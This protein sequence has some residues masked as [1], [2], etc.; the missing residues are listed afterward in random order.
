MG[1]S[2][3]A[4]LI[5]RPIQPDDDWAELTELVHRAYAPLAA[6]GLRFHASYQDESVTRERAGE[7][8]CYLALIDGRLIGTVTALPA[9]RESESAWYRRSDTASMGQLA[10]DPGHQGRRIG[11]ALMDRAEKRAVE[12]GAQWIA[13]DTSEHATELIETYR[14]R[15]YEIVERVRWDVTNYQSVVLAKRLREG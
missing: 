15:G 13:I 11:A 6:R 14:R 2:Q 8:E 10:V 3:P 5:I 4:N 12:W 1:A 7:G 9:G